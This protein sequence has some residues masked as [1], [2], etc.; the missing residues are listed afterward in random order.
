M[1]QPGV[2]GEVL[3]VV[4]DVLLHHALVDVL[5]LDVPDQQTAIPGVA[6]ETEVMTRR[7]NYIK[8]AIFT[9][10]LSIL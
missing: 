2:L 7:N 5:V 8:Q 4:D 3:A 10:E 6:L 1:S 9:S